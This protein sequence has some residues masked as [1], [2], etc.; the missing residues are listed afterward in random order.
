MSSVTESSQAWELIN[1]GMVV[2]S[3][4]M[5]S[6]Q[7]DKEYFLSIHSMVVMAWILSP[8]KDMFEF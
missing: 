2:L 1:N 7:I 8:Q 3:L 6:T 5:S 4:S